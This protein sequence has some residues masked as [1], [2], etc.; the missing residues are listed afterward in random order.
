MEF[1]GLTYKVEDAL[2]IVEAPKVEDEDE[3]TRENTIKV[4]SNSL[5]FFTNSF[6]FFLDVIL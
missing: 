2:E 1:G 5:I 3:N 4:T 6:F